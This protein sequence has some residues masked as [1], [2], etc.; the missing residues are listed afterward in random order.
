MSYVTP[1]ASHVQV[2]FRD[3][4]SRLSYR[5]RITTIVQKPFSQ[6]VLSRTASNLP[7]ARTLKDCR[8]SEV[9]ASETLHF[10]GQRLVREQQLCIITMFAEW[11]P[12]GPK[13]VKVFLG[14]CGASFDVG[15]L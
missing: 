8:A 15:V 5:T 10:E 11:Y 1:A 12:D 3:L 14:D 6:L 4:S 9:S 2:C 13:Q 7:I